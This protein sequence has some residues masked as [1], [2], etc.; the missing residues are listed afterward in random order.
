MISNITLQQLIYLVAVDRRGS[1]VDAAEECKVSQP[2]LSMQIRKLEN[3]LGVKVFDRSRQPIAPTEIGRRLIRQARMTLKEANRVQELVDLAQGEMKGE[4]RIASV[5]SIA[6]W[7][8]P[9]PLAT[10]R[11]KHPDVQVSL[12]ELSSDD[13]I[14]GLKRDRLDAAI[15]PI[16]LG[17]ETFVERALFD[18]E[19]YLYVHRNH[20]LYNQEVIPL[21]TIDRE[22]VLLPSTAD[23][24]RERILGL[25]PEE[26]KSSHYLLDQSQ[27][28]GEVAWRGAGLDSVRMMVEAELG[29]AIV[30]GLLAEEIRR[31]P[32]AD[33]I[34]P[35]VDPVP[36]RTIGLVQAASHSRGHMTEALIGEISVEGQDFGS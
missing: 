23:G 27:K 32:N 16:P 12:R 6:P 14:E 34:R 35:F 11:K 9:A 18:E 5:R 36:K 24:L 19:L 21:S 2:A 10:F 8:L 20:R 33:M 17:I 7:L 22:E 13:I 28:V 25:F 3:T 26:E 29:V 4:Y 31:G 30:P 1:F 15:L